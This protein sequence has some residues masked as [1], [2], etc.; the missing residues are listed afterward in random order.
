MTTLATAC[1]R[2]QPCSSFRVP[3]HSPIHIV[4][5]RG[6]SRYRYGSCANVFASHCIYKLSCVSPNRP[7]QDCSSQALEPVDT[8][9]AE[10]QRRTGSC[11]LFVDVSTVGW[12]GFA[13]ELWQV[14]ASCGMTCGTVTV[15][16]S[17]RD[18]RKY[19]LR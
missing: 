16:V 4:E 15:S 2:L 19:M 11:C 3:P 7:I 6:R 9:R 1:H 8:E 5:A 14:F 13:S 10:R 17:N 12:D 18:E